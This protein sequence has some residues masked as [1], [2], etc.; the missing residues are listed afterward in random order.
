MALEAILDEIE[1]LNLV[2]ERIEG[3]AGNHPSVSE[4]LLSISGNVRA[5]ATMLALLAHLKLR[6]G[7]ERVS[8]PI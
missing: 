4:A 7:N 5:T 1:Q 6:N 2:S 8:K 3:L